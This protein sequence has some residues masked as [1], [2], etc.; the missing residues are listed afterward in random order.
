[1]SLQTRLSALITAIGNE[2]KSYDTRVGALEGAAMLDRHVVAQTP[3]QTVFGSTPTTV[4]S[5]SPVI[6]GGTYK[7][8]ISFSYNRDQTNSDFI[9]DLTVN[10]V[11]PY[12]GNH[13]LR[14]EPKDSAGTFG[15]TGTNQHDVCTRFFE[16]LVLPAGA[17]PIDLQIW[18]D[19]AGGVESSIWDAFIVLERTS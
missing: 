4:V 14:R 8:A 13:L 1:M 15:S 10:G 9:A 19:G 6:D 7:L 16:N 2:F 18:G 5:G 17:T 11:V 3:V 12:S